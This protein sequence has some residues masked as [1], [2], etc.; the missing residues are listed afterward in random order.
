MADETT[1][2]IKTIDGDEDVYVD[3]DFDMVQEEGQ[4]VFKAKGGQTSVVYPLSGVARI[5]ESKDTGIGQS[6]MG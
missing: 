2:R 6:L 3:A 5:S 4:I 1:W